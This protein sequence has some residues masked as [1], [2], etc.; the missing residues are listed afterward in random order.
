MVPYIDPAQIRTSLKNDIERSIIRHQENFYESTRLVKAIIDR[1]SSIV[2]TV[3]QITQ[4]VDKIRS[5]NS[6]FGITSG[7]NKLTKELTSICIRYS[8]ENRIK[9]LESECKLAEREIN[10]LKAMHANAIRNIHAQYKS[11]QASLLR[12]HARLCLISD[13]ALS[14][15]GAEN[16]NTAD[17]VIIHPDFARVI[18]EVTEATVRI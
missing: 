14:W 9:Y 16:F 17:G 3:A 8:Q 11:E 7:H 6:W 1:S 13:R 18:S 4:L 2:S 5:K 15:P 10:E 12:K